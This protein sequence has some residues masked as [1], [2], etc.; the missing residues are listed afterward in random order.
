MR[1]RWKRAISSISVIKHISALTRTADWS[2]P[3]RQHQPMPMMSRKH[4]SCWPEKKMSFTVTAAISVQANVMMRL[5]ATR[6]AARS[7][8][9]LTAVHPR[10]R[11]WA[12]AASIPQRK[13]NTQSPLSVQKWSMYS[14]SS[15]NNCVS[16]KHDIEGSKSRE[17]NSTQANGKYPLHRIQKHTAHGNTMEQPVAYRAVI[18]K[19]AFDTVAAVEKTSS[20]HTKY[21]RMGDT[22]E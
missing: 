14:G 22:E 2:V 10:W 6:L 11:S 15:R 3:W 20:Q 18:A 4:Q 21:P 16:E 9:E 1:I 5:S 13:Q 19:K 17:P 7:N 12:K 8:T